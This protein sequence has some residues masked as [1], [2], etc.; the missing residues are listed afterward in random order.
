[1]GSHF[2]F[3][4]KNLLFIYLKIF[5]FFTVKMSQMCG[6]LKFKSLLTR[7]PERKKVPIAE[8]GRFCSDHGEVLLEVRILL[9]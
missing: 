5:Y 4:G 7:I 8:A 6:Q 3:S 2:L 1:M 9:F